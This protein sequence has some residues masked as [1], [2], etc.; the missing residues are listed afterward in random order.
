[1]IEE[2]DPI[3]TLMVG[4]FMLGKEMESARD[5]AGTDGTSLSS[6]ESKAQRLASNMDGVRELSEE[7]RSYQRSAVNR[8]KA[9]VRRE[10]YKDKIMH[11]ILEEEA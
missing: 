6:S 5:E 8:S 3:W 1:M 10:R 11:N 9:A 7:G 4:Y 2:G